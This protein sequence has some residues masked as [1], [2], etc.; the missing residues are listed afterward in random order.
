MKITSICAAV[1]FFAVCIILP[2]CVNSSTA[3]AW[4]SVS[5]QITPDAGQGI[6][7]EEKPGAAT[8]NAEKTTS[9]SYKI[10]AADTGEKL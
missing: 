9:D 7:L 4:R 5:Y 2:G 1:A 8:V 10:P 3:F 6:Q